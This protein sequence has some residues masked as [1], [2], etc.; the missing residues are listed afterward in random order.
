MAIK[1]R[2]V[3]HQLMAR[4]PVQAPNPSAERA[5]EGRFTPFGPRLM[6]NVRAQE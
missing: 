2:R 6:A 3:D 1:D 4:F 5:A